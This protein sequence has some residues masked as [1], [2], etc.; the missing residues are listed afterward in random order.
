MLS[1]AEENNLFDMNMYP[2]ALEMRE[3]LTK[4]VF[5]NPFCARVGYYNDQDTIVNVMID[6]FKYYKHR[7]DLKHYNIRINDEVLTEE[8]VEQLID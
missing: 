7:V 5:L 4:L 2:E 3:L 8:T 6:L 1:V